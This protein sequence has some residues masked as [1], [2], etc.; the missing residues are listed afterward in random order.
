MSRIWAE[1]PGR[2]R[3]PSGEAS[4]DPADDEARGR[5]G[6]QHRGAAHRPREFRSRG[7]DLCSETH[8]RTFES[9]PLIGC[10]PRAHH[11]SG[12]PPRHRQSSPRYRQTSVDSP[13]RPNQMARTATSIG[14]PP[15]DAATFPANA[16][17]CVPRPTPCPSAPRPPVIWLALPQHTTTRQQ[18]RRESLG[19]SG[20]TGSADGLGSSAA[21]GSTLADGTGEAPVGGGGCPEPSISRTT[22]M[23]AP[24]PIP[25]PARTSQLEN[26][27]P[28]SSTGSARR[29]VVGGA[30]TVGAG[31]VGG[32]TRAGSVSGLGAPTGA[33]PASLEPH[34]WQKLRPAGLAVPQEGQRTSAV[35]AEAAASGA[36]AAAA[37]R[38]APQLPQN[39][40]SAELSVPQRGHETR[41]D[42]AGPLI[43]AGLMAARTAAG[44][45]S[46][47]SSGCPATP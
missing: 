33:A 19:C 22:T 2:L 23:I 1:V 8:G 32:A 4:D 25:A 6:D 41:P 24:T 36:G 20:S 3:L 43:D 40:S 30:D 39:W 15:T 12:V 9:N 10:L 42:D 7:A 17:A 46:P 18:C 11:T 16:V 38:S 27:R 21:E 29:D 13:L 31:G 14:P 44:A 5:D 34:F 37:V 28:P 26:P 35:S 47:T 45:A